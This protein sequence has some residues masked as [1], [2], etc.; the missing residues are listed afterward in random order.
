MNRHDVETENMP[1]TMP[2][3]EPTVAAR[4]RE[5]VKAKTQQGLAARPRL[6][7]QNVSDWLGFWSIG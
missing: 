5:L 2:G 3:V 7:Q 1:T 6:G 4:A